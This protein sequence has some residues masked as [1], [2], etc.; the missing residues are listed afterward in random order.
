M[1]GIFILHESSGAGQASYVNG[2]ASGGRT[3]GPEGVRVRH[4]RQP[5]VRA[6]GN[7]AVKVKV[8]RNMAVER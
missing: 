7:M 4:K 2:D 3:E 5:R 8:G 1:H 6:G